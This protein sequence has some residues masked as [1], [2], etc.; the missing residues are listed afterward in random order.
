MNAITKKPSRSY[1]NKSHD[2]EGVVHGGVLFRRLTGPVAVV[3]VVLCDRAVS[4][5][6]SEMMDELSAV[7]RVIPTAGL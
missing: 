2:P 5:H 4:E 1:I 6:A 3:C 7:A